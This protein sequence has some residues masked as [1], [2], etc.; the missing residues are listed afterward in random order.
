M[1]CAQT[2]N[3]VP[4]TPERREGLRACYW[5]GTSELP[6]RRSSSSAPRRGSAEP[7]ANCQSLPQAELFVRQREHPGLH[8]QAVAWPY[9]KELWQ[10][11]HQEWALKT[12]CGGQGQSKGHRGSAHQSLAWDSELHLCVWLKTLLEPNPPVHRR[13][14]AGPCGIHAL[15]HGG[16]PCTWLPGASHRVWGPLSL[17]E[18]N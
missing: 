18:Q 16:P 4:S 15:P 9:W 14:R 11:S 1:L 17:T 6:E 2:W 3:P 10:E 8:S 13:G 7:R 12:T 5:E